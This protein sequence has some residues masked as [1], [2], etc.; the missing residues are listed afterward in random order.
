MP[1]QANPTP[2]PVPSLAVPRPDRHRVSALLPSHNPTQE[3]TRQ[4]SRKPVVVG[5]ISTTTRPDGRRDTGPLLPFSR[6][7]GGTPPYLQSKTKVDHTD[8]AKVRAI[9]NARNAYRREMLRQE[10]EAQER[11]TLANIIANLAYSISVESGI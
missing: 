1:P 10:S 11:A 9:S 5:P 3:F 6:Q 7:E 2:V 4:I 8:K